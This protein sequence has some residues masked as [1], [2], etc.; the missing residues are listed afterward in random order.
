ML[1]KRIVPLMLAA[2]PMT[3]TMSL[4]F[5][6][7][8]AVYGQDKQAETLSTGE[9]EKSVKDLQQRSS[10]LSRNMGRMHKDLR[11]H[12]FSFLGGMGK[13]VKD[14]PYTG[15]AVTETVQTLSDGNR[16]VRTNRTTLY[17]DSAGRTR[18][19][20]S[21][22]TLGATSPEISK[23]SIVISDPIANAEY[24]LDTKDKVARKTFRYGMGHFTVSDDL[25][26]LPTAHMEDLFGQHENVAKEDL[27]KQ[28]IAGLQCTGTRTT[29]T[30]PA[31]EIGNDKP[32]VSTK[33]IWYSS[34]IDGT[35]FSKST[36]PRFGTTTYTLSNVKL[37]EQPQQLFAPPSDY[38]VEPMA[39][40]RLPRMPRG[41]KMPPMP[42]AAP[43]LPAPPVPPA[44]Q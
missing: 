29:K 13:V 5:T 44:E 15:T 6:C 14:K 27:G 37:G 25:Q 10:E 12:A 3:I 36:D 26:V 11:D 32:I 18:R 8:T 30:I 38:K 1:Q 33:E 41:P 31:G 21:I 23:Q 19:E 34:E 22:G 17:R 4:L 7:P 39:T 35:V 40:P 16:I 2:L 28:T 20:Q 42:P 24:V 43:A 9:L